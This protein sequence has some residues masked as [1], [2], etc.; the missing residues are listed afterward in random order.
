MGQCLAVLYSSPDG[1][2]V[3]TP[4]GRYKFGGNIA[5]SFW[6]V[7]GLCRFEVGEIDEFL[8]HLRVH[9]DEPLFSLNDA[10][11]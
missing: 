10:N 9:D 5:G 4:D 6:H 1:W 3:F 2:V 11:A 7:V 8:P